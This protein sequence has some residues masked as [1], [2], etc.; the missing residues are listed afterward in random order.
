M[1]RQWLKW[2]L[3]DLTPAKYDICILIFVV[4]GVDTG[5]VSGIYVLH[6]LL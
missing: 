5:K 6:I 4:N 3:L 1:I 2:D